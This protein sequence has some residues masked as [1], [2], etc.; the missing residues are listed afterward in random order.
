MKIGAFSQLKT[1][2]LT[3]SKY[4]TQI[5]LELKRPDRGKKN[6]R[7]S[8]RKYSF[9][10]FIFMLARFHLKL[11]TR[12]NTSEIHSNFSNNLDLMAGRLCKLFEW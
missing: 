4:K 10:H 9:R 6:Q 2:I 8:L 3:N 11:E 1:E 7:V 12:A 5:D